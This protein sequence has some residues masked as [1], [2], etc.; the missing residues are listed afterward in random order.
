MGA[1]R[2]LRGLCSLLDPARL[3]IIGNTADDDTF[4]GLHVSPD[5]DT[6]AYTLAGRVGAHGWGLAD[7]RFTALEA[8]GRY[9]ADTWFQLGDRDLAT[10]IYRTDELRRG[11]T[12]SQVT[13]AIAAR[14][15]V[16]Q[17]LLPMSDQP[18]RTRVTL[19]GAGTIAFQDYLVHRRGRGRVRGVRYA[20]ARQ[21]RPAPGVLA[22][23]RTADAVILPPSNPIVSIGPILALPGVR[24]ALRRHRRVA[25]VT[26]LVRGLPI[27]G[28]LDRMLRGMGHEVSA[29]GVAELYRDIVDVFVLDQRDAALAPRIAALGMRPVVTD[30]IMRSPAQSRALARVVLAALDA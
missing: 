20:G 26:P 13:A 5:L 28:P 9:Y 25:A 27:K 18:V 7:D 17:C 22:A 11:R 19:A 14:H 30:T 2:F 15:G 4:F 24:G 21:A 12:L 6:V 29:V 1:A 23:L 16:R 3:T 8:L 10:H